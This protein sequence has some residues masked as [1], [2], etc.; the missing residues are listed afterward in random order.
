MITGQPLAVSLAPVANCHN[1]RTGAWIEQP[2][3]LGEDAPKVR[4]FVAAGNIRVAG[5]TDAGLTVGADDSWPS[6][7]MSGVDGPV[8]VHY[9]R[10]ALVVTTKDGLTGYS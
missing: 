2:Y 1:A 10:D 4:F 3:L 6:A 8:A 7:V 9:G 5:T